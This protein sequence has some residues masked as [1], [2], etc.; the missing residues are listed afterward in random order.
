MKVTTPVNSF[1]AGELSPLLA[2][3]TDIKYYA[4]AA[5]KMRNFVP[6][7]QGPVRRRPGTRFVAETRLS[8]DRSWLKPWITD[9]S[10]AYVMEF[11]NLYVRFFANHGVVGAP[12]EMPTPYLIADLTLSDGTCALRTV[13]TGDVMYV[14]HARGIY[15]PQKITRATSTIFTILPFL[16]DDG[17][18]QDIDPDNTIDVYADA[19]SGATVNLVASAPLFIKSAVGVLGNEIELFY[20]EQRNVDGVKFWEPGKAV[21]IGDLRRSDSKNYKALTAGNTGSIKPTHSSHWSSTIRIAKYDG[22]PGVQWEYQ[23]AGYGWGR[24]VNVTDSTHAQMNVLSRLPDGIVG[25]GNGT[26]R[27]AFGALN[28]RLGWPNSVTIHRERL[29]FMRGREIWGSVAGDFES[30]LDREAGLITADMALSIT[31]Y[32]NTADPVKWMVPSNQALLIGTGSDESAIV[33]A[34]PNDPFG[35]GNTALHKQSQYGSNGVQPLQVGDGVVF[36]SKSGRVLRDMK[37]AESVD[38]KWV[39]NNLTILAEHVTKTG[40]IDMAYAADPESIVWCVRADGQLLGF[41]IDREQEVHGWHPHRIG[42]FTDAIGQNYAAVES[43][44]TIPVGDRDELWM[45]V[46]RLDNLGQVRRYVEYVEYHHEKGDNPEDAFYVD[47]GLSLNNKIMTGDLYLGAGWDV[48]GSNIEIF[49]DGYPVNTYFT[50]A[51]IGQFIQVP[52]AFRDP[53]GSGDIIYGRGAARITGVINGG[54]VT[55]QVTSP[56]PQQFYAALP[57]GQWR[58]TTQIVAGLSHLAGKTVSVLADGAAHPDVVVTPFGSI[59]LQWPAARVHVGLPCPAILQPMPIEPQTG[60]STRGHKKRANKI[61]IKFN[62]TGGGRY[63][64]DEGEQMDWVQR[65]DGNDPMSQAL[66]LFSGDV[67]VPWPDGS[68]DELLVTI[69]QNQAFPMTVSSIASH[70]DVGEPP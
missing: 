30:F 53:S 15:P 61:T 40:I 37:L 60:G 57:A 33:E 9:G 69:I 58:I 49:S 13:Q 63:G 18:F 52:Y 19:V 14:V 12:F 45:I 34:T 66:A 22:D 46:R 65:R 70:I 6:T 41:T 29:I 25:A 2:G 50:A 23:N 8:T 16:S 43:V 54:K 47:C 10:T 48:A 68:A 59:H 64:R 21:V 42:G 11:G 62:E 39:A 35:P 5:R 17:P 38:S 1:N 31:A 44:C 56:F 4:T 51:S 27:F 32:T 3:R 67:Q 55:A 28:T 24:I 26:T 7:A 36:V 20:M